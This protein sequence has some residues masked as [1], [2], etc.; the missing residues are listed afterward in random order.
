MTSQIADIKA[1]KT[2]TLIG[3]DPRF[4]DDIFADPD[5]VAKVLS[6]YFMMGD[7]SDERLGRL[8]DLP[9]VRQIIF[10]D[11]RGADIFLKRIRGMPS[12][13]SMSFSGMN[14]PEEAIRHLSS[15]P[16]LKLLGCGQYNLTDNGLL[17]LRDLPQLEDLRI[18]YTAQVSDKGIKKLQQALPDCKITRF[19]SK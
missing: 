3:I 8:R 15:F 7:M 6:I 5:C 12:V 11:V 10:Y 2:D 16:N 18:E 14:L 19:H 13:E 4:I 17:Q 9:N 1:G